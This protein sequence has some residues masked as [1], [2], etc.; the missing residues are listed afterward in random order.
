MPAKLTLQECIDV[1]QQRGGECLSKKYINCK[2]KM[3]WRCSEGHTWSAPFCRIKN[4][5]TWCPECA[6]NIKF[7]I[8]EV[9]KKVSEYGYKLLSKTYINNRIPILVICKNGHKWSVRL[10]GII[11]KNANCPECDKEKMRLKYA[12]SYNYI[13]EE[14]SKR[15]GILLSTEYVNA[16]TPLELQC[17][18]CGNVWKNRYDNIRNGQWCPVCN[19]SKSQ[20][21]LL[22]A[23]KTLFPIFCVESNYRKFDWLK[24]NKTGRRLE[25]DIF[26]YNTDKSFTLAI[27]YD[28]EQHFGPVRFGGATKQIAKRNFIKQQERDK[29]KNKLIASKQDE[30]KFFI[31]FNYK[32]NLD[33][34]S[35]K[36][37]LITN[38]IIKE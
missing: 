13:S 24:N 5:G 35:V 16:R 27:E 19:F 4:N 10:D 18:V 6:N 2:S 20:K 11:N 21:G 9:S 32:D 25:I 28:G 38:G 33:I 34:K 14:I 1:A 17:L 12:F 8:D 26:I 22:K 23:L 15:N 7:T 36:K 3:R 31:R 29:L 30:I 37:K